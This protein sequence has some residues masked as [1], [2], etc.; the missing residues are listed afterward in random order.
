MRPFVLLEQARSL[1]K[2]A[3][4]VR[5]IMGIRDSRW[6]F[7]RKPRQF[8]CATKCSQDYSCL[9]GPSIRGMQLFLWP[10]NKNQRGKAIQQDAASNVRLSALQR[11]PASGYGSLSLKSRL[12]AQQNLPL[13]CRVSTRRRR[14]GSPPCWSI[15]S[16][17]RLRDPKVMHLPS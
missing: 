4:R 7:S 10:R 15:L 11:P 16:R 12:S 1:G 6:K 5:K 8:C 2:N 14:R 3:S 9:R 17:T 13:I